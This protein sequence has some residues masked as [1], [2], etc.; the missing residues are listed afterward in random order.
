LQLKAAGFQVSATLQRII[1]ASCIGTAIE[2]MKINQMEAGHI[3][4]KLQYGILT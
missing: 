1:I 3:A 2:E 4:L